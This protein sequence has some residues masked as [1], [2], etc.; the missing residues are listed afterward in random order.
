MHSLVFVGH[1]LI[2]VMAL[3][4]VYWMHHRGILSMDE[5]QGRGLPKWAEPE[6]DTVNPA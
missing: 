4:A 2:T 6:P 3:L 5:R 1:F